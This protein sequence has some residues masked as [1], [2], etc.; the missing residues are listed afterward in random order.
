METKL[1]FGF[2]FSVIWTILIDFAKAKWSPEK[3]SD[4]GYSSNLLCVSCDDLSQF[5]L[6]SLEES[7]RSCCEAGKDENTFRYAKATLKVCQ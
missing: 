3:C 2:F 1:L 6:S 7:C 5:N 4:V